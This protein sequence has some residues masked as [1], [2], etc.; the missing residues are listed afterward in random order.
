MK[1]LRFFGNIDC[2]RGTGCLDIIISGAEELL[3]EEEPE[4]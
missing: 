2:I 4:F 3:S 1:V